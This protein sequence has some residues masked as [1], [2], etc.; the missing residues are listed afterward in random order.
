M[1]LF[2]PT[3]LLEDH[4]PGLN[5]DMKVLINNA[6]ITEYLFGNDLQEKVK[7]CKA[8]KSSAKD[9]KIPQV[10][11][12]SVTKNKGPANAL[13]SRGLL[14]PVVEPHPSGPPFQAVVQPHLVALQRYQPRTNNYRQQQR[15]S[16]QQ[17]RHLEA[18]RLSCFIND[19][20][21]A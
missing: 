7:A 13:N 2:I 15:G 14:R 9:L 6:H 11:K 8:T 21:M 5:K 17:R 20:S 19:G 10:A 4:L 16:Q 12:P 1:T 3:Q 18:G